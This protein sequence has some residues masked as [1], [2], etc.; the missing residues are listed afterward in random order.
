MSGVK[1]TVKEGKQEFDYLEVSSGTQRAIQITEKGTK[2]KDATHTYYLYSKGQDGK[3]HNVHDLPEY[4]KAQAKFYKDLA[5]ALAKKW[6]TQAKW[7]ADGWQ[8]TFEKN[9]ILLYTSKK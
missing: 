4:N 3:P 5:E 9:Q 6:V 8:F 2:E 7:P 1:G